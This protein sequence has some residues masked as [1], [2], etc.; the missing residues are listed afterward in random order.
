MTTIFIQAINIRDL[1]FTD[2]TDWHRGPCDT[3][4][5]IATAVSRMCLNRF[6]VESYMFKG[7]VLPILRHHKELTELELSYYTPGLEES[8]LERTDIPKLKALTATL[9]QAAKIVPGRP[10]ESLEIHVWGCSY[11]GAGPLFDRLRLASRPIISLGIPLFV[12]GFDRDKRSHN[13]LNESHESGDESD[14]NDMDESFLATI[15]MVLDYL[16]QIEALTVT[17]DGEVSQKVVSAP[18]PYLSPL[19]MKRN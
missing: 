14:D 3:W 17:V 9:D 2:M 7:D 15:R 10:V 1:R 4:R 8:D 19:L 6:S 12:S 16:P 13:K 11:S 18:I 5:E